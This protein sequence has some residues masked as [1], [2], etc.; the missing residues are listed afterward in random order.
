MRAIIS[1]VPSRVIAECSL[2]PFRVGLTA[3]PERH[4]GTHADLDTLIGPEVSR[5]SVA[6]LAG[7]VLAPH[8]VVRLTV[9][10]SP[11]ERARYEALLATRNAFLRACGLRLGSVTGW[12]ALVRASAGSRAGRR[13]MRAPREARALAF[14]TA[15]K[16][17]VLADLL[18]EHYPARTLIFTEDTAMV[19]RIARDF[20]LPAITHQTPVKER[21]AILPRFHTGE[22]PVV[23]ASR[24]L[25]EGVDVPEASVAIVLSSTGSRR[26]YVQRLGRILRRRE[27][28]RAVLYEVVAAATSEEQVSRR[29][30]QGTRLRGARQ[31]AAVEP[32]LFADAEGEASEVSQARPG[33][34]TEACY[35][36]T[37]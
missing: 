16:L 10:L 15:G 35:P 33:Q 5:T 1:R 17:R 26:E 25:N 22:Y 21:H 23:V 19:Y 31:T 14:G 2:A 24:V 11:Q 20:L 13:A 27:G 18:A 29:R 36:P 6:A 28:K 34:E 32:E 37:C 12:Q 3:T 30:R 7:T 4:D 8:R 9:R